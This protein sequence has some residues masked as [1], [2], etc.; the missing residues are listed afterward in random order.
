MSATEPPVR[1][2]E[3]PLA[4]MWATGLGMVLLALSFSQI[5]YAI[6]PRKGPFVGYL[7]LLAVIFLLVWGVSVLVTGRLAPCGPRRGRSGPS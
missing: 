7:E 1:T 2:T 5:A 6:H 4:P 3:Q